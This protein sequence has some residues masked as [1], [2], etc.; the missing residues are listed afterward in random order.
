MTPFL[1]GFILVARIKK[2]IIELNRAGDSRPATG[3]RDL[4]HLTIRPESCRRSPSISLPSSASS[5]PPC[6]TNALSVFP[7]NS[8]RILDRMAKQC[9][10]SVLTVF[11]EVCLP[12]PH[13]SAPSCRGHRTPEKAKKGLTARY[14]CNRNYPLYVPL[15]LTR[16]PGPNL[17]RRSRKTR[18][19]ATFFLP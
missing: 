18:A 4:R 9:V 6:A 17:A 3:W 12:T 2:V 8:F 11:S 1:I 7:Y 10:L 14:F 5:M 13:H 15:F 16:S 19:S